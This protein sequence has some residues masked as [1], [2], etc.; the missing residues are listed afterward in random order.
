M[1]RLDDLSRTAT[2]SPLSSR[3]WARRLLPRR[4]RRP[5]SGHLESPTATFAWPR[6]MRCCEE[7]GRAYLYSEAMQSGRSS[8]TAR[9][10]GSADIFGSTQILLFPPTRSISF[11]LP[12]IQAHYFTPPPVCGLASDELCE[13]LLIVVMLTLFARRSLRWVHVQS[14]V[15]GAKCEYGDVALCL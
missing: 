11:F 4:L 15:V 3:P 12:H 13:L 7:S 5:S 9:S 8:W 6:T 2:R 14:G 1:P 10:S